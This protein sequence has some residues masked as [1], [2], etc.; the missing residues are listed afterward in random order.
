MNAQ[1]PQT[2]PQ[3]GDIFWVQLPQG[4]SIGS[5]QH[6]TRPCVVLSASIIS[7]HMPIAIIVPL[8]SQLHKGNRE[9]RIRIPQSEMIPDP[10]CTCPDES[11]ALSEQVR[12][13]SRDRLD[14]RR[15]GRLKPVGLAAVEAGVKY[16]L[17]LV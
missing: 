12:C 6:G 15:V 14:A 7:A 4:Q 16:V 8:S 17:G 2:T 13:I 1:L 5:E 11:I 9:F 3:R 10:G